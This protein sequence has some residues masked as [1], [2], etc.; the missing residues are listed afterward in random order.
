[1]LYDNVTIKALCT[2]KGEMRKRL[3]GRPQSDLVIASLT[4]AFNLKEKSISHMFGG[5]FLLS[6]FPQLPNQ[7]KK[8]S[9]IV[10]P[11][12]YNIESLKGKCLE[13]FQQ[14][15]GFFPLCVQTLRFHGYVNFCANLQICF[16][17]TRMLHFGWQNSR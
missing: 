8:P 16:D 9:T 1:M 4:W 2:L 13:S 6:L 11:R 14:A 15:E 5:M 3:T 7:M 12:E 10:C 17:I